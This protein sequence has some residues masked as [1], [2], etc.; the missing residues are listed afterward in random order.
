[1]VIKATKFTPE[2]L[3]SAPRRS[4]AIP[5][6]DGTLALYSVSAYSFEDKQTRKEIYILDI[7]TGSSKLFTDDSNAHDATWIGNGTNSIMW[8]QLGAKGITSLMIGDGSEPTK[9]SYTADVISAPVSSVKLKA[10]GDGTI[11]CAMIGLA[12]P[13][14]LLYNEE[15]AEKPASSARIYDRLHVRFWDKYRSPQ[16]SAIWYSKL[17][18]SDGKYSLTAPLRNALWGTD[19]EFP[20]YDP[21]S[22]ESGDY[23]ISSSGILFSALNPDG[24]MNVDAH[25]SIY[26]IPLST[27]TEEKTPKPQLIDAGGHKG[28]TSNPRFSPSATT[29]AFLVSPTVSSTDQHIMLVPDLQDLTAIDYSEG[30]SDLSPSGFEWSLDG[31]SL[32]LTAENYG[33]LSLYK[34]TLFSNAWLPPIKLSWDGAISGYFALGNSDDKLLASSTSLVDNSTYSIIDCSEP[35]NSTIVS[36]FSKNGEK[37]GLSRSQ[38]YEIWFE[39]AGDYCVHA[40]VMKPHDFDEDKK[41]PL[42]LLIHGGPQSSWLDSWSTRWNPAVWAE[43]GYVCI[44][45]NITGSTGY[46]LDFVEGL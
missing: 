22:D 19:L 26:F 30:V 44:M 12:T 46:G 14:G 27:F 38:V 13:E 43:Q 39:G 15:T 20:F 5:N 17:K 32:L 6:H 36:S 9:A 45:P 11:A 42:A 1:M 25:S 7:N 33:R 8:L 41:Y 10:L 16:R 31:N 23:D 3:L 18:Q 24:R 37:L 28:S 2:V 40:W 21:T 29:A 4:S 34:V 35:E